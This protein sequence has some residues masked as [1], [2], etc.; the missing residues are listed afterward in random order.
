VYEEKYY[1]RGV[2]EISLPMY[3]GETKTFRVMED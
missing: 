1:G 3:L 2:T